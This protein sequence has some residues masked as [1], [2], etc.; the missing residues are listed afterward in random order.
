MAAKK[1][2]ALTI[3]PTT[4]WGWPREKGTAKERKETVVKVIKYSLLGKTIGKTNLD[5]F[6]NF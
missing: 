3:K 1:R 2:L 6:A 5:I 4:I